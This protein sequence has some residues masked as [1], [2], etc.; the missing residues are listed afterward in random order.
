MT[1]PAEKKGE[2]QFLREIKDTLC[3]VFDI[4]NGT[5][6]E[7]NPGELKDALDQVINKIDAKLPETEELADLRK[8]I[9]KCNDV[10][11]RL[12]GQSTGDICCQCG[13]PITYWRCY[14]T[15]KCGLDLFWAKKDRAGA[16][17]RLRKLEG[18]SS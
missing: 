8:L 6:Q 14:A 16:I 15:T 17:E 18:A 11:A 5:E 1:R 10:E 7:R 9:A 12:E 13:K 3:Y 4:V 2:H